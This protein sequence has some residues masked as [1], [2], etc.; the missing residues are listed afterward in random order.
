MMYS[1]AGK[2]M[3]HSAAVVMKDFLEAIGVRRKAFQCITTTIDGMRRIKEKVYQHI[4][5]R[6][7][8]LDLVR[9][10]MNKERSNMIYALMDKNLTEK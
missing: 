1:G 5:I 4:I 7:D 9:Y 8:Q 10:I 2:H 3:E 6:R